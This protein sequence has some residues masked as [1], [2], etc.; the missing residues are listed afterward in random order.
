MNAAPPLFRNQSEWKSGGDT[1]VFGT[2]KIKNIVL[3]YPIFGLQN[4]LGRKN[5]VFV[6]ENIWRMRAQSKLES[7]DFDLFDTWIYNMI[8]WL[9]IREDKRRFKVNPAKHLFSGSEQILFR[10]EA[11]DE[12]YKPLPG[13]DIKLTLRHP[14]GKE[15]VLYM[16]ETGNARYFQ[17]L[18]NLEEGTYQY[19]AE[20][21]KNEVKI[22]SDRG[23]FS[24]GKN[25]IEHFRLTAD[26][27]LLEQIALRTGGKFVTARQLDDLAKEINQLNSLKP[28]VS[29]STRRMGFNEYQW[30]FFILL[31]LLALE[32]VIRK[33]YSLS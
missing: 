4:H 8:Q 3:D 25:N 29:Y 15:D 33:R 6:G 17:E 21:R 12:S 26:K 19:S 16:N 11:Y 1:K 28:V 31:G 13:V 22:G 27:G 7:N 9:I 23:E 18:S 5:M 2:A 30:I 32:W 10:G 20:G 14:D 24:I